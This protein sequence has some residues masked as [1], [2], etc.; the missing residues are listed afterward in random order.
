M[1][2]LLIFAAA[3]VLVLSC[4]KVQP[5]APGPGQGDNPPGEE[6]EATTPASGIDPTLPMPDDGDI[7][8]ESDFSQSITVTWNGESAVIE[9]NSSLAASASAGNVVIGEKDAEGQKVKI[10]L[11]GKSSNGSLTIYNGYK[12]S[13]EDNT[14]KR[15]FLSLAGVEL[16]S[17][18]RPAINIQS[19]KTV[20]IK[21]EPSTS[22]VLGDSPEYTSIPEGEDAKACLFSEAQLAFS[23]EGTLTV[24]GNYKHAIASDDYIDILGGTITVTD[25][26]EHG[27]K[28]NDNIFVQGGNINVNTSG[29]AGKALNSDGNIVIL[30]GNLVLKTSGGGMYDT[31]EKDTSAASCIKADLNVGIGGNTVVSCTSSGA[32]GKGIN[33]ANLIASGGSVTVKTSGA[34]Y[35]YSSSHSYPKAI[36][37]SNDIKIKGGIFEVS[38]TGNKAEGMEAKGNIVID[39]GKI[40]ITAKDDAVNAGGTITQNGGYLYAYSTGNDGIDSNYKGTGAICINGGVMMGHST[41][42][43]E[44]GLDADAA[45]RIS[46]KGGV[47][48]TSGGKQSNSGSP[49][50]G[51]P[52]LE[53]LGSSL[54][55]GFFT[56]TDAS[57]NVIMSCKVPRA[58]SNN[59]SYVSSSLFSSGTTYNYGV[60]SSAP[61]NPDTY[62]Y[63][64]YYSGGTASV[65]S[66]SFTAGTGYTSVG[67]NTGDNPGVNPPGGNPG[68]NRPPR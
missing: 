2:K 67:T 5:F 52:C 33:C 53:I 62:W 21:T 3:S 49:V 1:K 16:T 14:R 68:G 44:E 65:G 56:V 39:E 15:V 26:K 41:N 57:G 8:N 28:A 50:C 30:S 27:I 9:N 20:Y 25:A 54:T 34:A 58:I 66:T 37:A 46:I 38:T 23:G 10:T 40:A 47:V 61:S 63:G 24:K 55:A 51:Q 19:A 4:G 32:G 18:G 13:E 7:L 43:P 59:C 11:K 48:F 60:I 17:A 36:K 45:N 42:S 22:N 31:T 6:Q 64:Y 12:N 29:T 35:T